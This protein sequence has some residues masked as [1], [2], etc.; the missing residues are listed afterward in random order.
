MKKYLL[1][2]IVVAAALV[3]FA[4]I[5]SSSPAPDQ[6]SEPRSAEQRAAREQRRSERLES[7]ARTIDSIVQARSFQFNPQTM[8]QEPA[9]AMRIISNPNYEIGVWENAVDICIPYIKGYVPPYYLT[10]INYTMPSVENYIT[11]QTPEG[12]S[13]RFQT[14]L[15]SA[16][17]YTFH[18]EISTKIGGATLTITNPWYNPVQYTGTISQL[19]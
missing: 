6:S 14:S 13:V 4:V 15:F 8:Q 1:F 12:W 2:L 9:G 18:F 17:T 16:S 5:G 7:Y 19:Y 11:E 3:S 10:V